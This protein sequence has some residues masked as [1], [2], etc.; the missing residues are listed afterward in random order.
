MKGYCGDIS[1]TNAIIDQDGWLHTGDIGYYDEDKFFYVVDRLKELIKY[2]GFQVAPAE[3]EAV[4]L[5]HNDIKDA[6]VIGLPDEKAG[7]LPLAFVV[8]QVNAKINAEDV[9]K[10][11]NG[12]CLYM[13]IRFL[14]YN[15]MY[16]YI[17]FYISER[18]SGEKRLRGGVRFLDS[19]PKNQSG[20]ILRRE[21]RALLKSKL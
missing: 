6:A 18:V 3:L 8:K 1:A 12:E 9:Q 5:S 2:K 4:L 21:L 14:L 10:Y 17:F 15:L 11:V 20:K 19:I 16:I 7:E 13:M